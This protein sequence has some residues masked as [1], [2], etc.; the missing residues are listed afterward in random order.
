MDRIII[1]VTEHNSVNFTKELI[2][3]L[4]VKDPNTRIS[5]I[6]YRNVFV[7]NLLKILPEDSIDNIVIQGNTK[8]VNNDY[9]LS[10][11]EKLEI[12]RIESTYSKTT[13]WE[14]IFQDRKLVYKMLGLEYSTKMSSFND[15]TKKLTI[16]KRFIKIEELFTQFKPTKII[17]LTQDF[18]TSIS[19]IAFEV[20]KHRDVQIFIPIISKFY[21]RFGI[22]D[23]IYGS[24]NKL[25]KT[26]DALINSDLSN[27]AKIELDKYIL[28]KKPIVFHKNNKK[29]FLAFHL[30]KKIRTFLK[31]F[32]HQIFLV[33]DENTITIRSKLI[34]NF[35]SLFR[36][37]NYILVSKKMLSNIPADS[38]IYFPLHVEPELV[39]LTQSQ[40]YLN[41]IEIINQL[42]RSLP[43]DCSLL[44]KDHPA[45][46]GRRSYRFYISLLKIP[47]VKV[48]KNKVNSVELISKSVAVATIN[49]SAGL[50][51]YLLSKKVFTLSKPYYH[52]LNNIYKL[53][54]PAL[55]SREIKEKI[56]HQ[57]TSTDINNQLFFVEALFRNTTEINLLEL[58][59]KYE[60]EQENEKMKIQ[61]EEYFQ[62]LVSHF[63]E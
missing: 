55:Y 29:T 32:Y 33:N 46:Y 6:S 9:G 11:D 51:A 61:F 34:S 37:F 62:F 25:K 12:K 10:F 57:D 30:F 18:G 38:F 5:L 47:N 52:F 8:L 17:Y 21:Q 7:K 2:S 53:S 58:I 41:Q 1:Y 44:V 15:N 20:A 13:I 50:E 22:T 40:Q 42:A 35:V 16:L 14:Y 23:D 49:G 48:V 36:K 31:I 39:L 54:D 26:Y 59:T 63:N 27:K 3:R 4:K 19:T 60:T 24:W 43:N 45:S 56:N 28:N